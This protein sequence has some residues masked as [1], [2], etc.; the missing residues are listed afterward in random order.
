MRVRSPRSFSQVSF[1]EFVSRAYRPQPR[2]TAQPADRLARHG[3]SICIDNFVDG[4]VLPCVPDA[5]FG[6]YLKRVGLPRGQMPVYETASPGDQRALGADPNQPWF[7]NIL[8]MRGAKL[9]DFY[10]IGRW[11]TNFELVL[12]DNLTRSADATPAF[13][14]RLRDAYSLPVRKQALFKAADAK[15]KD[16]L[17]GF[18]ARNFYFNRG[19]RCERPKCAFDA[20]SLA[21][22]NEHL[23]AAAEK[24]LG[25][26]L[27]RDVTVTH[28]GG[29]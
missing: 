4:E 1:L 15:Q 27:V 18:N 21:Y 22:V 26:D 7:D 28:K 8:R 25:V 29:K 3:R 24:H 11:A 14:R 6:P 17:A 2:Y 20:R 12:H 13:L 23:D 19:A 9:R 10:A 16:Y 5:K